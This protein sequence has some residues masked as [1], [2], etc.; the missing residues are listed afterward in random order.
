[1]FLVASILLMGFVVGAQQGIHEPGTG[2]DDP[3]LKAASQGTGQ[4]L[5]DGEVS[6]L[7]MG[8]R[9]MAGNYAGVGGQ[10]MMIQTQANNQIQL[11]VNGVSANCGL[12]LIQNQFQNQTRLETKLSNGRN[13]EVRIMPD[14]ASEVA[15]Q[16]L[17]LRDCDEDCNI[18]LME[19]GS[20]ENVKL[21]YE[22]RTQ[23]QSKIFGLFG[24]NMNVEAQVDAETGEVIQTKKPWW[25]FLASEPVEE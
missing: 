22:M 6:G 16:R 24:A 19:I 9:V 23:K 7:G 17:R 3:E 4:G 20:G 5:E 1:M 14:G 21:A 12:D 13:A 11:K 18:E 15:L 8:V 25:A 2:L 10:Q